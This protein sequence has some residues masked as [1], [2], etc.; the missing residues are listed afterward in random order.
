ALQG[1]M[2]QGNS[3]MRATLDLG[4]RAKDSL[5]QFLIPQSTL[6][7]SLGI[8]CT[9][10]IDGHDIGVLREVLSVVLEADAPVLVHAVTQKGHGYAPAEEDPELF[11]GPSGFDIET[12]TVAKPCCSIPTYTSVFGGALV[13][14]AEADDR[15]VAITA[16][17]SDGTGLG[18]FAQRFPDR[19][20]DTGIT[21]EHAVG[22]A[23][24]LATG[25]L[26]PVV[27][28]YSTFLQ[29]A[30]DQIIVDNAMSD[31]DVVFAVDRSG[32]V[33]GDGATH[34]G[35]FDMSYLRMVPHMRILA[36]SDEAELVHA[37]HTAINMPGMV[38]I[39][40]PRGTAEGAPLP[41][42][43]QMLEMGKSVEVRPGKDVAM[44]AFGH[45]V[46]QA[47]AAAEL[48]AENG[49]NA[50]V[51]DM[52]WAKPLDEDAIAEAAKTRLV[53]TVEEGCVAGGAGE[54]VLEVLSRNG[55]SVPTAV[56]GLPDQFMESAPYQDLFA[57]FGLD[58]EGIAK[59]VVDRL[60]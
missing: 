5:K 54:G 46:T 53:V 17:M 52:R 43:P 6:F 4:R 20:F 40:Y 58:A 24:G 22:L 2:E 3:F 12:G 35:S 45:M 30:I 48:L 41:E 21:E 39:R 44:L 7:E 42:Q 28:I 11:H 29:R 27:A 47:R 51:V 14:E 25:G 38:A 1:A 33:G 37:L 50:R 10:P 8:M 26:K 49:I 9:S 55:L 13:R 36:P 19:F 59:T 34:N 16:A 15:V 18:A 60:G 57:R 56:L 32:L 31:L 23:A